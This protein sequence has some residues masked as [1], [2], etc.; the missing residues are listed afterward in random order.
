MPR[1]PILE[2]LDYKKVFDTG[3]GYKD[4]LKKAESPDTVK[5]MEE[6]KGRLEL[7]NAEVSL[8]KSISRNIYI[9][10]IAEDWC[11]DV[12]R[13]V[14]VLEALASQSK[15][16]QVRYLMRED[17]PRVFER[18]LTNGGEAIP[19]FIFFNDQFVEC[20]HFGPMPLPLK[21]IISRG[22][23]AGDVG[24]ARKRVGGYYEADPQCMETRAELLDLILT[25][26]ATQP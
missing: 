10:A 26:S 21:K 16:I 2:K 19:K 18:F 11:G 8:L 15:K 22:K 14:P 24:A 3:V 1:P 20:G 13:H 6:L 17:N 5:K 12:H 4:W 25:A 9:I 7:E 23:A